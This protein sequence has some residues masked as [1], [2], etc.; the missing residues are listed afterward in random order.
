MSHFWLTK[1]VEAEGLGRG[2]V[3]TPAFGNVQVTRVFDGRD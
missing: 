1:A 2:G 3:I